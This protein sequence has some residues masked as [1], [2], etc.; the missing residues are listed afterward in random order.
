MSE[1][2]QPNIDDFVV[3][4]ELTVRD[5]NVLLNVLNMPQQT[6]VMVFAD[7]INAIQK[8]AQPQAEKAAAGVAAAMQAAQEKADEPQ[9]TT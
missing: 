8:Q 5:I 9:A 2:Q 4:I 6:P 1:K 3:N 7:L